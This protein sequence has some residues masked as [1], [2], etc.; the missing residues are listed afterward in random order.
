MM[1]RVSSRAYDNFPETNCNFISFHKSRA[2]ITSMS[3][4]AA[5][6]TVISP[7]KGLIDLTANGTVT[8]EYD[9]LLLSTTITRG[10]EKMMVQVTVRLLSLYVVR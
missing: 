1:P 9:I 8:C 3:R 2:T 10:S 4:R 7:E 6:Q 5:F